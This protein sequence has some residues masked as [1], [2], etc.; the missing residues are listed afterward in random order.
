MNEQPSQRGM[1]DYQLALK[2]DSEDFNKFT[3]QM[4][5][6]IDDIILACQGKVRKYEKATGDFV[7]FKVGEKLL[8]EEGIQYVRATLRTYMNSNTYLAS[9]TNDDVNNCFLQDSMS[10]VES[11][12]D[13]IELFDTTAAKTS[14]VINMVSSTLLFALRKGQTDKKTIYDAMSTKNVIHSRDNNAG[15]TDIFK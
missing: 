11:M 4:E 9:L 2:D 13:S 5:L 3:Q 15:Q 7:E 6:V 8:N 12:Y 14:K 1:L 10:F